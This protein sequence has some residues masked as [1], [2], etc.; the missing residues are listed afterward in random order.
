MLSIF[1]SFYHW[2]NTKL[3]AVG[4]SSQSITLFV[5][6]F[7]IAGIFL[8]AGAQKLNNFDTTKI[9]FQ[10]EYGVP[11]LSPDIAATLATGIEIVFPLLLIFGLLTRLSAFV[12]FVFN[13][14]AV[15]SY[16]ALHKGSFV[17]DM[18]GAIPIVHFPTQGYE[19]HVVWGIGLLVIFAF[20]SGKIAIDYLLSGE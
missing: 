2:L 11:I 1:S 19:D 16:A 20:G 18:F 4:E 14:I 7:Y 9:L 3:T 10:Y 17:I 5:L 8:Q 15:W 13:A 12:L 6:R